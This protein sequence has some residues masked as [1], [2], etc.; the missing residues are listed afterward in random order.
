MMDILIW[1]EDDV[2]YLPPND[3]DNLDVIVGGRDKMEPI[4]KDSCSDTSV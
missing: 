1:D 3:L 2:R 4:F